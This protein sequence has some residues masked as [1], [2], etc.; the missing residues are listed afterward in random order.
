M[1]GAEVL[2]P[3]FRKNVDVQPQNL[4][5]SALA[6]IPSHRS[7]MNGGRAVRLTIPARPEYISLCRLAL[8]GIARTVE[9]DDETLA[10]LKLVL[11]EACSNSIRHAYPDGGG[12][13][14]VLY[15]LL[16]DR[17][18]LEVA[19]DGAGFV[20][21]ERPHDQLELTEGGLGMAIMRAI[22]DDLEL[23]P[24]ADGRGSR[25]RLVKRL[26]A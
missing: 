13:V 1:T 11:T 3:R 18:V 14:E 12:T 20:P 2:D 7:P 22:A 19:D 8:T 5:I 15:E 26:P 9:L 25:L 6:T 21:V 23:S 16:D 10:D 17:L 4:R 24:R